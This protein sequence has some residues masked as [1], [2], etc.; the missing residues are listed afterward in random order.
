MTYLSE[1]ARLGDELRAICD[2]QGDPKRLSEIEGD[3][4]RLWVLERARRRGNPPAPAPSPEPRLPVG[5]GERPA[6]PS[7]VSWVNPKRAGVPPT[8]RACVYLGRREAVYLS[9]FPPTAEGIAAAGRA[10]EAGRRARDRGE[11]KEGIAFA[12][13]EV[14]G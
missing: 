6:L 14:R 4:A 12:M 1:I 8:V 11:D 13:E 9:G 2:R 3:I 7:G 5:E 10:A